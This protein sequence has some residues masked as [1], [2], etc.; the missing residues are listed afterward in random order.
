MLGI[1]RTSRLNLTPLFSTAANVM[2]A[3]ADVASQQTRDAIERM[4]HRTQQLSREIKALKVRMER[5]DGELHRDGSADHR[6]G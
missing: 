1:V 6:D 2:R 4:E 3:T 5:A